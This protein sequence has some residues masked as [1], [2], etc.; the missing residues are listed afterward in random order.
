MN[1]RCHPLPLLH[2][3]QTPQKRTIKQSNA[4]KKNGIRSAMAPDLPNNLLPA[5]RRPR[6]SARSLRRRPRE[7]PHELGPHNQHPLPPRRPFTIIRA[8]KSP[9][10]QPRLL[11]PC[12]GPCLASLTGAMLVKVF[13]AS[14]RNAHIDSSN[15]SAHSTASLILTFTME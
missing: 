14:R 3:H 13:R 15:K 9:G 2:Q 7:Q 11:D 1:R 8:H 12:T 10:Q 4:R 6:N 5:P